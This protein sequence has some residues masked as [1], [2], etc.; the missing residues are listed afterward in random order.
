MNSIKFD[1]YEITELENGIRVISEYIPHFRSISL[2][3]WVQAGSRNENKDINGVTHLIEHLIFKGTDKRDGRDIA[4]EFDSMGAEFNGFTDKEICCIYADFIDNYL[5]KCIELLFDIIS[6]PSF[7]TEHIRTEKKVVIEEIKML[8]ESPSENVVNYFY[9]LVFNGHPLSMPVMGTRNS[10][11]KIKKSAILKHFKNGFDI[12]RLVVSAAGN[13][14][15]KDLVEKIKKNFTLSKS[16]KQLGIYSEVKKPTRCGGVR[17]IPSSKTGSVHMCF[18][19]QGCSR[20]SDDKY[21][22]SL[23]T[24]F[25]GGSMSSRLF[26]KIREEEG[27]AYS[28]FSNNVQYMDTGIIVIYA[29]ASPKNIGRVLE[30]TKNEIKNFVKNGVNDIEILRAKENLKGGIVLSV[31]DIS[32]RMFRLGKALLFGKKVL[33]ISQILKKI[34][35]VKKEDLNSIA[36]RYFNQD[37]MSLVMMGKIK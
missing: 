21:P 3:F 5:D 9:E 24:N 34:D 18:G 25:M 7:Q 1:H 2:G 10:V 20:T 8:E 17:K 37:K 28:I 36:R 4:I 35:G 13:V 27:L 31:E 23:I 32:S 30:L 29:A 16:K 14:K 12:Q 11:K 6:N 33:T 26:Q 19:S 22:I 15:H